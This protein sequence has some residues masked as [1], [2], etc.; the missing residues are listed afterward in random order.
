MK[1]VILAGGKGT[2]ISEETL[3]I[4][5][6]MIEIGSKPILWHIMKIYS[7]YGFN[8]FIVCLGYLGYV[9]KEYFSHYFLH[10]SDVTMDL[11]KNKMHI[12]NTASEPWQV[13]LVDTG[14]ETMTAGRIKRIEKYIGTDPFLMTYGDGVGD[15][16]LKALVKFHQKSKALA[17]VTAVQ[18]LGRF[19]T[20]DISTTGKVNHFLEKPQGDNNW[21]NAG[22]FVLQP[23]IF[24]Y[25]EADDII[26]EKEPM[27]KL[28]REGQ[29]TAYK[30]H[31][32]W[33]PMDALRDK[34]ELERLWQSGEAPWKIWK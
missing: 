11:A 24:K 20:L 16:D 14:A 6:P 5:K 23:E 28:S 12:H 27:E 21:I 19:G 8:E 13:T 31:G 34:I 32:F 1:V 29:L 7:H 25:I 30:H 10:M 3:T 26:W 4:P 2:R 22:F 15:I 33:R 17:T 9:V 18:P